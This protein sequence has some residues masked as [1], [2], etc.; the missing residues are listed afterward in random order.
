MDV[1]LFHSYIDA[2]LPVFTHSHDCEYCHSS[3]LPW[4]GAAIR[5]F[6]FG[7]ELWFLGITLYSLILVRGRDV[8]NMQLSVY[9]F[10]LRVVLV[11]VV[12]E[13]GFGVG[14]GGQ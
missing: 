14:H 13:G 3:L 2:A 10:S 12:G 9:C 8:H 5:D 11:C 6:R 4:H 7:A 1:K